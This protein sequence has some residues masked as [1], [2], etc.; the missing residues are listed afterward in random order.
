VYTGS[1]RNQRCNAGD[2][3]S[4]EAPFRH[5]PDL[6]EIRR[7][8]KMSLYSASF[9]PNH[10]NPRIPLVVSVSL[11]A[12]FFGGIL[13][14]VASVNN[15][16]HALPY[17]GE[18]VPELLRDLGI[19][20]IV[21]C[22]VAGLFEIYRSQRHTVEGM[23]DVIDAILGEQISPE[24]WLELKEL[25]AS[26]QVIRRR[27]NIR[28]QFRNSDSLRRNEA[29]LDVEYQYE[30]HALTSKAGKIPVQHELDY[31]LRDDHLGLPKFQSLIVQ[32][33]SGKPRSFDETTI[34]KV[35]SNG[36][37]SFDVELSPRD[38]QPSTIRIARSELV[39]VPGA[40]N[41]YTPEFM[42]D[43]SITVVNSPN[44][45]G[46]E[47]LVRPQGKGQI[48]TQTGNTWLCSHLLLPGQGIEI[49]FKQ[50]TS[51]AARSNGSNSADPDNEP[52]ARAASA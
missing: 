19:A 15:L 38:G 34:A 31:Q 49:K 41:L 30:L 17:T 26:K 25:I 42:K 7:S 35:V 5:P 43:V 40:Y 1:I 50:L 10:N 3:S 47:V 48:M 36:K 46:V 21:S 16:G 18:V 22:V 45:I 13:L 8:A 51:S 9:M 20:L 4:S 14:L 6:Q 27:A 33:P 52:V 11:L 24:V 44:A 12:L 2:E 39:H 23:T 37:M 29:I 32:G 28:L